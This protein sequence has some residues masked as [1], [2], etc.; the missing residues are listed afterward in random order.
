[1]RFACGCRIAFWSCG[2]GDFCTVALLLKWF[3]SIKDGESRL[4]DLKTLTE[5]YDEITERRSHPDASRNDIADAQPR[6]AVCENGFIFVDKESG[7]PRKVKER[8]APRRK[9]S[10]KPDLTLLAGGFTA[11]KENQNS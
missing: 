10:M 2:A 4:S 6:L 5:D 11:H 7:T 9:I 8:K 3:A 1:L